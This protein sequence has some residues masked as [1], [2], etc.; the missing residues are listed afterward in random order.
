LAALGAAAVFGE[1]SFLEKS[2]ISASVIADGH[3]AVVRIPGTDFENPIAGDVEFGQR[4][5]RSIA[6]T[7]SRRL[8]AT[9]ILV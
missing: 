8:R 7:L 5:Y 6:V 1:M 3:V 4:F 2:K 9:N